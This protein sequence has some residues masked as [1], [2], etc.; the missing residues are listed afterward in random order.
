M[1]VAWGIIGIIAWIILAFW[2][3]RWAQKKGYSFFLFLILSWFISFIL[4]LL[5]IAFLKDK[6]ETPESRA[7]DEAVDKVMDKEA[8]EVEHK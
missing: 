8:R 1:L 6:T 5:I 4:T 2:P 3:A 7:A